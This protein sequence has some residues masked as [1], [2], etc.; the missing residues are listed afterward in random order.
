MWYTVVPSHPI[1]NTLFALFRMYEDLFLDLLKGGD[2]I[3]AIPL[4]YSGL[5][6]VFPII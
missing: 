3:L 5:N 4:T 1:I 6:K 2:L